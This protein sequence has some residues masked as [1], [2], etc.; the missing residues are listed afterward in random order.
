MEYTTACPD[1]ERRIVARE[2]L[3]ALPPLF[4]E[5]AAEAWE[6]IGGVQLGDVTGQSVMQAREIIGA[7][8]AANEASAK[9]FAQGM[10]VSGVLTS[11]AKLSQPPPKEHQNET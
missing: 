7:A 8:T 3:I 11:D 4:P 9:I 6:M 10:Q 2:S 5:V 1:W